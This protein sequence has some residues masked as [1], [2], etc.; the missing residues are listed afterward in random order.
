MIQATPPPLVRRVEISTPQKHPVVAPQAAVIGPIT[1]VGVVT[2]NRVKRPA[3]ELVFQNARPTRWLPMKGE[4]NYSPGSSHAMNTL[5]A[6]LTTLVAIGASIPVAEV[7]KQNQVFKDLWQADFVWEYSALPEKG[8]VEEWRVPYSGHIYPDTSGG[9]QSALRKYDRA[10]NGGR[11]LAT[12]HEQYD[13]SAFK[14]RGQ[15]LFGR[16]SR[17]RTPDWHGHCNG[18]TSAAIRHAEPVKSVTRNG[19][20][21]SPSDIK[22]LLAEIYIYNHHEVLGGENQRPI[23]AGLFHAVMTNWVGRGEHPLGMEAD[24]SEEKWNYPVYAYATSSAKKNDRQVEVKMNIAYA[25]DSNG[26]WDES[27][28][29]KRVKY[30]HYILDLDTRGRIVGGY[31]LRD[32]NMIDM[33]WVPLRPKLS[34]QKGNESGNPYV[35]VDTVLSIW[36][37]SVPEDTRSK[38]ATVDAA[39]P[40]LVALTLGSVTTVPVAENS[41]PTTEAAPADQAPA[42]DSAEPATESDV[43][44]S[45]PA[46]PAD[47]SESTEESPASSDS[48]EQTLELAPAASSFDD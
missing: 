5:V 16:L 6:A 3:T 37:E 14:E 22:G 36:R 18:W 4:T 17:P 27:P 41:A 33:L 20:T 31:F 35:N 12:G 11:M 44:E 48:G 34:G 28:R 8:G 1:A 43:P 42:T 32:S 2:G 26:E 19:V 40:D 38:W 47:E 45:A 23:N 25:K 30:F 39:S 46:T 15:G 7:Q 10:Y 9:T 21:F 24:P 29:I 13:T